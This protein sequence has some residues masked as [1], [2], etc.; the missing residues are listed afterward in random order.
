MADMKKVR[1]EQ[2]DSGMVLAKNIYSNDG[3]VLVREQTVLSEGLIHRLREMGLPA[4]YI[5]VS[6]QPVL[7]E[8]VSDIARVDLIRS[9]A[10][11]DANIRNGLKL[12]MLE[13]R[14]ALMQL[15]DEV[16]KTRKEMLPDFPDI[17]LHNGYI[18]GHSVN[19]CVLAVKMGVELGYN[20]M[21]LADMAVGALFH[22]IG[23][24][25]I[26][27]GILDKTAP[28]TEGEMQ[29]IRKH[30]ESGYKLLKDV[31]GISAVA[32]NVA[33]Q[34]HERLNGSGYPRGLSG[35]NIIEFARIAAIVDVFDSLTTEK[36]YRPAISSRE[37]FH[38]I[39]AKAGTDYDPE[40]LEVFARI[41]Q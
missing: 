33:Y 39:N 30:P 17:R 22:D 2:M 26:P 36:V 25:Q 38:C 24:T 12:D 13:S 4:A 29:L 21:K 40:L 37:A 7:S 11:L 16:V 28:L 34:H 27:I 15:I 19:V 31:Y 6:A 9:L 3:R 8:L 1:I 5:K 35:K 41:I 14:K 18:Y 23:M 20:Q 32:S 10:K